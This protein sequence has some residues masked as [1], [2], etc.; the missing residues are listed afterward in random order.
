MRAKEAAFHL[1]FGT[2]AVRVRI[3]NSGLYE[4]KH[5]ET[6]KDGHMTITLG[7]LVNE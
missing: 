3:P 7:K 4:V 5:I 1:G 2:K 6:R